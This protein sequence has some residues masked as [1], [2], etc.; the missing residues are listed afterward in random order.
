MY[1]VVTPGLVTA[2]LE[3]AVSA[4]T[5]AIRAALRAMAPADLR[6]HHGAFAD[7]VEVAWN[8]SLHAYNQNPEVER[9]GD[10]EQHRAIDRRMCALSLRRDGK[11]QALMSWFGVHATCL[12][13]SLERL[14]GDNKGYAAAHAERAL[15]AAGAVTP[16]A[17]FA[18]AT[19]GDV[20]PHYHGPGQRARR[21]R[22]SGALEYEYAER[23]GQ[24]QSERVLSLIA[25]AGVVVDG[26]LDGIFGY[27]DFS[28]IDV[29]PRHAGGRAD[30]HTS[31]PCH[32][33]AFFQGTPVDGPGIPSALAAA[34][35]WLAG[36]V[37]RRRLRDTDA[38]P[39]AERAYYRRLYEAQGN[40]A[41]LLEAGR[42]QILGRSLGRVHL[43]GFVDPTLGELKR[44]VRR[45]AIV[46]SALV[47]SVLPLQIV[48]LG[49]LA[50]VCVPGEFT[51]TA[52]ARLLRTVHE[53]LVERGI[54][55]V[56]IC[57]YCNDYMGYVTT[58]EEYGVQAYEGGHTIF[59]QWTLG[60][61]QTRLGAL[62]AELA[63]PVS[64]RTHD[65]TTRPPPIPGAELALRQDLP[66]SR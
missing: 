37:R 20:S 43:P 25:D 5:E 6:F 41:I 12:G 55:T 8:R 42:K 30:A 53:R 7:E 3:A 56:M 34:A 19:A 49:K 63:K 64:A 27:A 14:D 47:P 54:D 58:H 45:G 46:E 65:R 10:G 61:F 33:V 57:T 9:R 50:I 24:L 11:V 39:S 26:A 18:Q 13:N 29:D 21:A 2:H 1:N 44:Q 32:G 23:N 38:V 17:I 35:R 59:G 4:A 31:D 40:K 52:G 66:P 16:I 62:A 48:T 22:L 51:T 15:A 36:R 28:A 60:A